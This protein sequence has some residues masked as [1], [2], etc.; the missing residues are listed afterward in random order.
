MADWLAN[1]WTDIVI[2]IA[3]V[4]LTWW[5]TRRHE[6]KREQSDTSKALQSQIEEF[7]EMLSV[8]E[9]ASRSPDGDCYTVKATGEKIC[10]TCWGA[11]HKPIPVSDDGTGKYK[12]VRCGS[13]G[14]HSK[15]AVR[16][17]EAEQAAFFDSINAINERHCK[18]LKW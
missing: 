9:D 11:E 14:V 3:C 13:T 2:P 12:C 1:N 18:D 6:R 15:Q 4:L 17:Y 7:K 8:Y 16:N 5:L 10:P